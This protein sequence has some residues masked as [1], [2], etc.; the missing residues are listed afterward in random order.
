MCFYPNNIQKYFIIYFRLNDAVCCRI[1]SIANK[2]ACLLT[3]FDADG[4][5]N[6]ISDIYLEVFFYII[7]HISNFLCIIV[8]YIIITFYTYIFLFVF[9]PPIVAHIFKM[10]HNF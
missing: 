10:L 4:T 6:N 7:I 5:S 2:Y 1:R 8:L 9:S 3:K